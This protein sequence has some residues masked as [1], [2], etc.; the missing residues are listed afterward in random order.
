MEI[1]IEIAKVSF[2]K[3]TSALFYASFF[4]DIVADRRLKSTEIN[5]QRNDA[6]LTEIFALKLE[7]GL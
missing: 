3:K 6:I 1:P 2:Q 7:P 4:T 5:P